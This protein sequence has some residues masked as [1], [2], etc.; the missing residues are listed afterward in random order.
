MQSIFISS[1]FRDMNFERDILN[2]RIA[3]K[4]NHQLRP[5]NQSI[6]IL[7][8]RWG[9]D[10]SNM[11]EQD[12]SER[13]LSVCL[14]AID[15]C[16]PYFIVLIGDRY[17]YI[18]ENCD[19][20]VTH[21]EIIRG[22]L[23]RENKGHI[24]IYFRDAD[25]S[26]MPEEN[27]NVYIEQ[28]AASALRLKQL[29]E[30]LMQEMPMCCRR[31]SAKWDTEANCLVSEEFEQMLL[32]DLEEDLVQDY[33][34]LVYKSELQKY[35]TE[36]EETV[37]QN[38]RYAYYDE[39]KLDQ[40]VSKILQAK[41]PL[42]FIGEAGTGKS[43]YLS[44][45]YGAMR[46]AGERASIMFCGEGMFSS[47][48]RNVA[49]MVLYGL[50]VASDLEYDFP[51]FAA[52][53]YSELIPRILQM[54][55]S[56]A[57]KTYLFLDAVDHCDRDVMDFV[58]WC[59]S[60]LCDQLQLVISTRNT[61]EIE[62]R[63]GSLL[64]EQIAY[65]TEDY[66]QMANRILEKNGKQINPACI[67]AVLRKI[68][69][70]LQLQLLLMRLMRL[71]TDDFREIQKSGGGIEEINRYLQKVIDDSPT[72][73]DELVAV[74]LRDLLEDRENPTFFLLLFHMLSVCR[75]GLR[76][77][78]VQP[79]FELAGQ[80]WTELEYL[81]FLEQYAFFIRIRENGNLDL[82]HDVIRQTLQELLEHN[83]RDICALLTD[84]LFGC[85]EKDT[86][87]VRTFFHVAFLGRE[88]EAVAAYAQKMS[89]SLTSLEDS[90][91]GMEMRNSIRRLF[92]RDGGAF[93]MQVAASCKTVEALVAFYGLLSTSLLT[94][95]DYIQEEQ[96]LQVVCVITDIAFRMFRK[97]SKELLQLAV[98][99][100]Y[101]F[102]AKNHVDA[103][104][105]KQYVGFCQA[106]MGKLKEEEPSE[107]DSSLDAALVQLRQAEGADQVL[108][109]QRLFDMAKQ[110][111][112]DPKNAEVAERIL[113]ELLDIAQSGQL[114]LDE[115]LG[116]ALVG[117]LHSCF[118]AA[119][120]TLHQWEKGLE[121]DQ[122]SID[123]YKQ[124]LQTSSSQDMYRKYCNKVYNL[125]NLLEA[126][127]MTEKNDLALWEQTREAYEAFYAL[128]VSRIA[129]QA[130]DRRI[131][132]AASAI[133][134][135][136]TALINTGKHQDG[137]KK[138]K[139]GI[140]MML[141]SAQNHADMQLY[142]ELCLSVLECAYQLVECRKLTAAEELAGK[143]HTYLAAVISSGDQAAIEKVREYCELFVS[144]LNRT[145][146]QMQEP[147]DAQDHCIVAGIISEL[148][149]VILPIASRR[150]KYDLITVK[151]N[152]YSVVMFLLQ[153]YEQAYQAYKGLLEQV[154]QEELLVPDENGNYM[155]Q[156]LWRLVDAYSRILICLDK[157]AQQAEL[158][159]WLNK[160]EEWVAYF[161]AHLDADRG[162]TAKVL[163]AIHS[164]LRRNNC[165]LHTL[166]LMMAVNT[167]TEEGYDAQAHKKTVAQIFMALEQLKDEEES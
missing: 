1:T 126:W 113:Q 108:L 121:H 40:H 88:F 151:C 46:A 50:T 22:A 3:P 133:L 87:I 6:R 111:A 73:T 74:T 53:S 7:D 32:A 45:L 132:K 91:L 30:Q 143:S 59:N 38:R 11:T 118:G 150:Q 127:A 21:L 167:V 80:K 124:L 86:L 48:V 63:K 156:L 35:L 18:P 55:E 12:A 31:Y 135:L 159:K 47:S 101:E 112:T 129:T 13:V 157:T 68:Q 110:M 95:D 24:F 72:E 134:S 52:M 152:M 142:A 9:V 57:G 114:S 65:E 160:A 128:E 2:R 163:F 83:E 15:N 148:L 8:L 60:F 10:T 58:F 28:D 99:E 43:V 98:N 155:D 4:I 100:C 39:A 77:D 76:E 37:A 70:P 71:D 119:C 116:T 92:F 84:Y 161:A 54:R 82:S 5:Y 130:S 51:Q 25:Y 34:D 106:E 26:G 44:L 79:L 42:A 78:D 23:E 14:D 29:S 49:E 67:E 131:I 146:Y 56:A 117:E 122:K 107:E 97:T 20:S 81:E 115:A 61:E 62:A 120:K 137:M 145:L 109:W 41:Q 16:K 94:V 153:D 166:F 103:D 19:N 138:Y 154:K 144:H 96:A 123:I 164:A 140:A 69:T 162:D 102:L 93:M 158:E 89:Q 17:G 27:R 90:S 141:D 33:R 75:Y 36:S 165:P 125:A 136:G 105:I 85:E 104:K 66:R 149:E 147:K 64:C 139:E